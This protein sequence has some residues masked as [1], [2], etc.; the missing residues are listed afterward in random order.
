M[1]ETLAAEEAELDAL[2]IQVGG[3]ALFSALAQGFA[4]AGAV[5]LAERLP[6]FVAVQAAGCA[7]LVRAWERMKGIDLKAAA[8]ARSRF[9]QPWDT[10]PAS[11]AHGILDDETYDWFEV[12]KALR[13][14]G[15][16]AV[17]ADEQAIEK[18]FELARVHTSIRASATGTA[19][20][21]G[22]I[23]APRNG[24][25]AVVLSGVERA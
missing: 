21:A 4:M 5:G 7:P 19:G 9:M 3:G 11:L 20:L 1:A 2:T 10:T 13:E 24:A 12:V 6:T 23:A 8:R 22:V 16:D 17:A 15:G 14:T 25:V 18:A